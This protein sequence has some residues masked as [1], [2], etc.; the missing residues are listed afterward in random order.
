MFG[1]KRL[2]D[3]HLLA[4]VPFF[5]N[6]EQQFDVLFF[7][8]PFGAAMHCEVERINHAGQESHYRMSSIR[9]RK[10]RQRTNNDR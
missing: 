5:G 6:L 10:S 1:D 9:L 7:G 8:G 3:R 2:E 4:G